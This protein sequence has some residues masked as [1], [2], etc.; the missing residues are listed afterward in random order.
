VASG[1]QDG[2]NNTTSPPRRPRLRRNEECA[3]AVVNITKREPFHGDETAFPRGPP[4][5]EGWATASATHRSSRKVR[6]KISRRD[7]SI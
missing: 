1:W 2:Q 4:Q 3:R 5:K 7:A 6:A